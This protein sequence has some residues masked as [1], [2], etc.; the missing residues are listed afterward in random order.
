MLDRTISGAGALTDLADRAVRPL[1][2]RRVPN[3]LATRPGS[4]IVV[5]LLVL[6]AALLV[7][8]G[9]EVTDDASPRVLAAGAI[10]ADAG[11]PDRLYTT[12][13]GSVSPDYVETFFDLN[14]NG[15]R[16]PT[17]S[18]PSGTTSSSIRTRSPA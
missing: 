16:T 15:E 1:G 13:S 14:G 9:L 12:I 18:R 7:L 10:T 5:V 3:P 6:L 11:L 4:V 17:R 2:Q 8:A